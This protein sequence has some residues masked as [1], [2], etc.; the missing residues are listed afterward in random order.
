MDGSFS[1]EP[2]EVRQAVLNGSFTCFPKI[3]MTGQTA[4]SPTFV[5][6]ISK[7]RE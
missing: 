5:P 7:L 1:R 3:V 4:L 2:L 6:W